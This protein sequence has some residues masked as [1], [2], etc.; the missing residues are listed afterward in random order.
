VP[1]ILWTC[2]DTGWYQL[3]IP[4]RLSRPVKACHD[5][6]RPVKTCQDISRPVKT[7]QD[8]SRPVQTCQGLSRGWLGPRYNW[9]DLLNI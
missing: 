7:C 3:S 5:L 4:A 2:L 8:L 1:E 9:W 6:P